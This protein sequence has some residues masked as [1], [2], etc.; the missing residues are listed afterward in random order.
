MELLQVANFINGRYLISNMKADKKAILDSKLL[1]SFGVGP[2]GSS[3]NEKV[4]FD[5]V[6]FFFAE[7]G[8]NIYTV[9][10]NGKEKELIIRYDSE[11]VQRI[12][13]LKNTPNYFKLKIGKDEDIKKYFNEISEA[14]YKVFPSGLNVNIED[15]LRQSTPQIKIFKKRDSYRV[16]NNTGLKMVMSFDNCEYSLANK[17]QKY[18]QPT[19]DIVGESYKNKED[20]N[21]F[22][23]SVIIDFPKLIKIESN[24]LTVA[25]NTLK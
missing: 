11:Q 19:L 16:V 13:F 24:E 23:K 3:Y 8:I 2:L 12:E 20:F 18:M 9:N 15:Y 21:N 22:L 6:D 7:K 4:Y 14:I 17:K 10:I 1:S 5:T 25:R